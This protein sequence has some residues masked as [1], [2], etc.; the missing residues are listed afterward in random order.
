VDSLDAIKEVARYVEWEKVRQAWLLTVE[1]TILTAAERTLRR[2]ADRTP[3]L[4]SD[5]RSSPRHLEHC[6]FL[7]DE[8]AGCN[9]QLANTADVP[10]RYNKTIWDNDEGPID[11]WQGIAKESNIRSVSSSLLRNPE[12][13]LLKRS[14]DQ[15]ITTL[16]LAPLLNLT[17]RLTL[18]NDPWNCLSRLC[19]VEA[20][21]TQLPTQWNAFSIASKTPKDGE[22]NFAINKSCYCVRYKGFVWAKVGEDTCLILILRHPPFTISLHLI[23]SWSFTGE[24]LPSTSHASSSK[25]DLLYYKDDHGPGRYLHSGADL[26]LTSRVSRRRCS[27][28]HLQTSQP[29]GKSYYRSRPRIHSGWQHSDTPTHRSST[30]DDRPTPGW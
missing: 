12:R 4:G 29:S 19:R 21:P 22:R 16:C 17:R 24:G 11:Q 1:G 26:W 30:F 23:F 25:P 3:R 28:H 7:F 14:I 10:W 18:I 15:G 2:G 13:D 8:A 20:A 9:F 5:S 6:C 27:K